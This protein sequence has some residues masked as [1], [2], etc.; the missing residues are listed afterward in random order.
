LALVN[1]LKVNLEASVGP[2]VSGMQKA[3]ASVD[4]FI[5]KNRTLGQVFDNV[6][7]AVKGMN[8]AVAGTV[9]VVGLATAAITKAVKS[10]VALGDE[11]NTVSQRTGISVESL[12]QL[13][14]IA[15]QNNSSFGELQVGLRFLSRNIGAAA[16]GSTQA[17]K[18]FKALGVDVRNTDKSLKSTD[19]VLSEIADG[20]K[21]TEGAAIRN[22]RA[23]A[24]LG[25]GAQQLVPLLSQGSKALKEQREEADR[26]GATISTRFARQADEFG[27]NL[28]K[29]R[30]IQQG[31][32]LQ[33][34]QALVPALNNLLVS[35]IPLAQKAIP[36]TANA[37]NAVT[38]TVVQAVA[39]WN[40]YAGVIEKIT[41]SIIGNA[42][43]WDAGQAKYQE[44]LRVL[45]MSREEWLAHNKALLDAIPVTE[46]AATAT[47]EL[48]TAL[49]E[50][51]AAF[52]RAG[53]E[54]IQK[55]VALGQSFMELGIAGRENLDTLISRLT[56]LS[57]TSEEARRAL[58]LLTVAQEE[59]AAAELDALEEV[60]RRKAAGFGGTAGPRRPIGTDIR[61]EE[62]QAVEELE[63]VNIGLGEALT[64]FEDINAETNTL[65]TTFEALSGFAGGFGDALI[66]AASGAEGAFGKFFKGLLRQIAT[67]I[68]RAIVLQSIL[69][70]LGGGFSLSKI[71]GSIKGVFGSLG[72]QVPGEAG[73]LGQTAF[74]R[75]LGSS[76]ESGAAGRL[77]T[78]Q[79]QAPAFTVTVHEATPRTWVEI[80]DQH[81]V[82]RFTERKRKLNTGS[83][84]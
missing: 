81:I 60:S 11:L 26:L 79:T 13:K 22:Q 70:V 83:E 15:E 43:A 56:T 48:T 50:L 61:G 69:G 14:F 30:T 24:L 73:L 42:A 8:P 84:F 78:P 40:V 37:I 35:L 9:A 32:S 21:A 75:S 41:G 67:A 27:D 54:R 51:V 39:A 4:S 2:F 76:M 74:A 1:T 55:V 58:N 18:A 3:G 33:L 66:A 45:S 23:Q 19:Q 68:I 31:L 49:D 38:F 80:T 52:D 46:D 20:L 57:A 6:I 71:L 64:A 63:G 82:P 29:L 17:A 77:A 28:G 10:A 62:P 72:Q 25:R 7:G 53:E 65:A 5:S 47:G 12:S 36:A 59:S 16:S 34:A 44:G